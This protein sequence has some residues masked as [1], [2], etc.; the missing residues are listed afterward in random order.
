MVHQSR[1]LSFQQIA[2]TDLVLKEVT[3]VYR[4]NVSSVYEKSH[5]MFASHWSPIESDEQFW[6][7]WNAMT[8]YNRND[9]TIV[10]KHQLPNSLK[11]ETVCNFKSC[12]FENGRSL[13]ASTA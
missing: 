4:D 13:L 3:L 6:S 7:N 8:S 2:E 1:D 12:Y 10:N 5:N 9:F 11:D